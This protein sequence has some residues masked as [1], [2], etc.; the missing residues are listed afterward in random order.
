[1]TA[2][3]QQLSA[4]TTTRLAAESQC[5]AEARLAGWSGFD[6]SNIELFSNI[7]PSF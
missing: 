6:I 3:L 2:L 7:S 5:G 4:V 1:M